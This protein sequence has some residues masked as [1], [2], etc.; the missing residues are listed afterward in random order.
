MR[1]D[2]RR[3]RRFWSRSPRLVDR[4][5]VDELFVGAGKS[6]RHDI[7]F[8]L[9]VANIRRELAYARQLVRLSDRLR[10]RLFPH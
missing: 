10:I 1:E 6:I 9:K 2:C 4:V 8:P 5:D 3:T 7:G